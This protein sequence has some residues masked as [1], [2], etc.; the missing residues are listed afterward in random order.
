MTTPAFDKGTVLRS[1]PLFNNAASY[2]FSLQSD[3]PAL[4]AGANL[5]SIVATDFLNNTRP[6]PPSIGAFDI[7]SGQIISPPPAPTGLKL[8]Q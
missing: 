4:G 1:D 2:D 3:S 8:D 7:S 6:N 5:T